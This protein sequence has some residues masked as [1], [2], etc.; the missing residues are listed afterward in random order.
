MMDALLKEQ[1]KYMF[2]ANVKFVVPV[3]SAAIKQ[4]QQEGM[5]L[6]AFPSNQSS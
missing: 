2:P 4:H 1:K 3:V 6:G 5:T